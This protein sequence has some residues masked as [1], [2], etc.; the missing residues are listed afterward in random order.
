MTPADIRVYRQTLAG[1]SELA[2]L[3]ELVE[4]VERR[5]SELVELAKLADDDRSR[6]LLYRPLTHSFDN[7]VQIFL[8]FKLAELVELA[9]A[10]RR[11]SVARTPVQTFC[12]TA[13]TMWFRY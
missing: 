10:C 11:R 2:G 4:L 8:T 6:G 13:S 1:L 5:V 7:V 3:A 12:P 9:Q